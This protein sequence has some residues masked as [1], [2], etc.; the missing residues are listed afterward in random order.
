MPEI[1][2]GQR[3]TWLARK[4]EDSFQLILNDWTATRCL[5]VPSLQSRRN[6]VELVLCIFLTEQWPPS[7]ILM[8]AEGWEEGAVNGQK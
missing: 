4:E 5:R 1:V 8:E 3:L 7:L 6:F 2:A